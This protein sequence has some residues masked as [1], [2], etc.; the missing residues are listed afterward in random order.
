[1]GSD[2]SRTYLK[3]QRD[4]YI[5]AKSTAD[6]LIDDC[7]FSDEECLEAGE[8]E[9]E[10]IVIED[11]KGM[12][13]E[14]NKGGIEVK[15]VESNVQFTNKVG[16]EKK[17]EEVGEIGIVIVN[18]KETNLVE[19]T[20]LSMED[21]TKEKVTT[22]VVETRQGMGSKCNINI[23]EVS[24]EM[25]SMMVVA[26]DNKLEVLFRLGKL[27][28]GNWIRDGGTQKVERFG[29]RIIHMGWKEVPPEVWGIRSDGAVQPLAMKR[30]NLAFDSTSIRQ[31]RF[32]KVN[33]MTREENRGLSGSC[34]YI[35]LYDSVDHRREGE[36]QN[37]LVNLVN[38]QVY[39]VIKHL[40]GSDEGEEVMG[41]IVDSDVGEEVIREKN[42][43]SY[44]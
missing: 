39:K 26:V 12:E 4:I 44:W 21:W 13:E 10:E 29:A 22:M 17:V 14:P 6:D 43:C 8:E 24:G 32:I 19:E 33:M 31:E 42:I 28:P 25:G 2:E 23:E 20:K 18:Q 41:E 37:K 16:E 34:A 3:K 30:R 9:L 5:P 1:M 7:E 38:D 15:E 35:N 27:E 11:T 40:V 36:Q